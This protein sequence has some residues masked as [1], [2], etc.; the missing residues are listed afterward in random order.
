MQSVIDLSEKMLKAN[1]LDFMSFIIFKWF[2]WGMIWADEAGKDNFVKKM[3]SLK[4]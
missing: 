1:I 4:R 3:R 2:L